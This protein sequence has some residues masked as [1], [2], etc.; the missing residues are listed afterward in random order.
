MKKFFKKFY[1]YKILKEKEKELEE[2]KKY[3]KATSEMI[4]E[5]N[6]TNKKSSDK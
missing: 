1:Q 6:R 2:A 5:F 4:N 3:I